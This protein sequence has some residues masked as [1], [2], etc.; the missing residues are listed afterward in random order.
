MMAG[1]GIKIRLSGLSGK[2]FYSRTILQA[3]G[4]IFM[5]LKMKIS[6]DELLWLENL[7]QAQKVIEQAMDVGGGD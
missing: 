4:S 1:V 7:V 6:P 3:L 5:W 2:F